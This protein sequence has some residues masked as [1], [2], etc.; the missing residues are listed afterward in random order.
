ML[1]KE[2]TIKS[3]DDFAEYKKQSIDKKYNTI[4]KKIQ[5]GDSPYK[6]QLQ[7]HLPDVEFW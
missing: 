4:V 7:E 6:K 5:N 2:K 1:P 3:T